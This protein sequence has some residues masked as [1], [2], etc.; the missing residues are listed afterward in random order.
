MHVKGEKEPSKNEII[1][2]TS[3][4]VHKHYC[5]NDVESIISLMDD[6]IIWH[7]D[8]KDEYAIGA[9]KLIDV[10]KKFKGNIHKCSISGEEYYVI[11]ISQGAYLCSGRMLIKTD[12]S[13]NVYIHVNQR[14]TLVFRWSG[15]GF[16]CC[17]ADISN[18]CKNI[19][20]GRE[21]IEFPIKM[22]Y[23]DYIYLTKKVE[24]QQKKIEEQK[25][26]IDEQEYLLQSLIYTDSLTGLNN[27]NK[28][29]LL[30]N[31]DFDENLLVLGIAYFDLNGLKRVNDILGHSAGDKFICRAAEQIQ[32]VFFGK[33][34]R[35]G[36]D[37]FVVIDVDM[38]ETEF[39]NAVNSVKK[40]MKEN[41]ISSAVGI[42][43][44]DKN[45]NLK[46]QVEEADFNMYKDKRHFYGSNNIVK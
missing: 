15:N 2:L 19:G 14:I 7:G 44:R 1:K 18:P 41:N 12:K 26:K 17:Y 30:L 40:Q 27:R 10:F 33:I 11:E 28:F 23:S 32:K 13:T 4:I 46:E 8:G 31:S 39:R 20:V 6:D 24:E 5:E 25:K 9:E 3:Y 43:W 38:N 35:T 29:D 21:D 37:E 16:K 34:Y 36:G 42:S 22:S 45:C